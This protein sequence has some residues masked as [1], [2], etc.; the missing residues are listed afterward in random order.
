M[1]HTSL[2][3]DSFLVYGITRSAE[4]LEILEFVPISSWESEE[5]ALAALKYEADIAR[6]ENGEEV[7]WSDDL[8]SF[9]KPPYT[10]PHGRTE[11]TTLYVDD[12]ACDWYPEQAGLLTYGDYYPIKKVKN[13]TCLGNTVNR[14]K[15]TFGE[16]LTIDRDISQIEYLL[17][18]ELVS[19]SE[20]ELEKQHYNSCAE[21][22]AILEEIRNLTEKWEAAAKRTAM[23]NLAIER[24][25]IV[26]MNN[27]YL[28]A[29]MASD[30]CNKWEVVSDK[31]PSGR[32]Q[33][34]YKIKNAA[35]KIEIHLF[36]SG[37][38]YSW[39]ERWDVNVCV[40]FASPVGGNLC[41]RYRKFESLDKAKAYVENRK[42]EFAKY[43]KEVCPPIPK[44]YI[45]HFMVGGVLLP[46]YKEE[47]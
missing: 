11:I 38:Q 8:H 5:Q 14:D 21:E 18:D 17:D 46:G 36:P 15:F 40:D 29:L 37:F 43:F 16:S 9:Q 39:K 4:T 32:P 10:D 24:K 41:S 33:F 26:A 31:N 35:Y 45:H 28:D 12:A 6:E 42:K 19:A 44:E 3:R 23:Y 27:A 25:D 7:E 13:P 20:E 2:K 30:S 22:R 34:I 47:T 1:I